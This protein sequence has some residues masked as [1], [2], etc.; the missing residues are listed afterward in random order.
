MDDTLNIN[1]IE[2]SA[3]NR[4]QVAKK[5]KELAALVEQVFPGY[6]VYIERRKDASAAQHGRADISSLPVLDQVETVLREANGPMQKR[7]LFNEIHR[8]GG[9]ISENTLSI[10]LS[11]Y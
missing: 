10:Y 7:D 4:L 3:A 2:Q 11:R 6:G 5:A 8:R 1:E 9:N